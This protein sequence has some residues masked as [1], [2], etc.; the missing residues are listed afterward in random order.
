MRKFIARGVLSE[1]GRALKKLCLTLVL[2]LTTAT[3]LAVLPAGAQDRQLRAYKKSGGWYADYE[4]RTL[5]QWEFRPEPFVL[6]APK[7]TEMY[8]FKNAMYENDT[9]V[10]R[11][12][13]MDKSMNK[14]YRWYGVPD[15]FPFTGF[16]EPGPAVVGAGKS[17]K[18]GKFI[19]SEAY[20]I[21]Q[22][23]YTD[24]M[25]WG[26]PDGTRHIE[27]R[28]NYPQFVNSNIRKYRWR[29]ADYDQGGKVRAAAAPEAYSTPIRLQVAEMNLN[30]ADWMS[31]K[32]YH[33]EKKY[34][35]L[36][37]AQRVALQAKWAE[38]T[39]KEKPHYYK[40]TG[41]T[42]LNGDS[43]TKKYYE[44]G[45][46]AKNIRISVNGKFIKTVTL[47]DT[48]APQLIALNYRQ[49]DATRPV[50]VRIEILDSYRGTSDK[51]Y[52]YEIGIGFDSDMPQGI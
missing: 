50:S 6:D 40:I 17:R 10:Y 37:F 32:D 41:L 35:A 38:A 8:C 39:Q 46:R 48:P 19:C 24:A 14:K 45:S 16:D 36:T 22:R 5:R 20:A 4:Y 13:S 29:W 23:Y 44:A 28:S 7:Y 12:S 52:I 49:N 11:Y 2:I 18:N 15:S 27:Q 31:P 21:A 47:K 3:L 1:E 30:A 42:I 34:A 51:I 26:L 25:E 43:R 33:N 9:D